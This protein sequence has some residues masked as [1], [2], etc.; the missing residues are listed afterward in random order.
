MLSKK[1]EIKSIFKIFVVE[2]KTG[3]NNILKN[4]EKI[5]HFLNPLKIFC[6]FI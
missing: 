6:L 1:L 5:T 2:N 4:Q 3:N